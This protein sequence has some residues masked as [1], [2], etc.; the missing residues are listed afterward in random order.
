ML[1]DCILNAKMLADMYSNKCNEKFTFAQGFG[2]RSN[3]TRRSSTPVAILVDV[4][5]LYFSHN[6]AMTEVVITKV[7]NFLFIYFLVIAYLIKG[8]NGLA[9][10]IVKLEVHA[11]T[12]NY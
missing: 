8:K 9:R 11:L 6:T 10:C 3:E 12:I 1:D 7:S 2:I 4:Q 5:S